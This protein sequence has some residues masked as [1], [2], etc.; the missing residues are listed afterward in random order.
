MFVCVCVSQTS[1]SRTTKWAPSSVISRVLTPLIGVITPVTHS[2]GQLIG[3][4]APFIISIGSHLVKMFSKQL[5][6]QFRA[7]LE[8]PYSWDKLFPPS[9]S[10]MFM[11][12]INK[13][14][15]FFPVVWGNVFCSL[16]IREFVWVAGLTQYCWRCEKTTWD[17]ENPS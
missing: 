2:D 5:K 11:W 13:S 15:C 10:Y 14:C 1:S 6:K 4:I 17:V 3:V 9:S 16:S 12:A 8:A 7:K